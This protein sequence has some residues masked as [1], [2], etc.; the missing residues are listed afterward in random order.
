MKDSIRLHP[1][2]GVNASPII[3]FWCGEANNGVALLGYNKGKEAPRKYFGGY[4]P[5][6]ECKEK[7][8]LGIWVIE[9]ET[10]PVFEEQSAIIPDTYPTSNWWVLKE[11]AICRMLQSNEEMLE[12]VLA[13]GRF[14]VT[15]K[16]AKVMG[17]YP[18]EEVNDAN[19]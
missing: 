10:D 12:K 18:N 2:Y 17:L 11:D 3:C 14:C 9:A 19:I 1:E 13:N 15:R 6:D 7:M 16:D 4:E 5:C 8:Q